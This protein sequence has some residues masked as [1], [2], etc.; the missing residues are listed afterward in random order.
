[1]FSVV[2]LNYHRPNN[3]RNQILPVLLSMSECKDIIISHG[4]KD[5]IFE[6]EHEKVICRD[7]TNIDG[8]WG[9]G[10]R[11]M[12]ALDAKTDFIVFLDDDVL[13]IPENL[14]RLVEHCIREPHILHGSRDTGRTVSATGYAAKVPPNGRAKV[15]LTQCVVAHQSK[16]KHYLDWI[17]QPEQLEILIAL[18]KAQPVFNGE[19]ITFSLCNG[20]EHKFYQDI[21]MKGLPSPHAICSRP[22]HYE[23][24]SK[25]VKMTFGQKETTVHKN[26]SYW[27]SR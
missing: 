24:R 3:I 19:D 4:K 20:S 6:S 8:I 5:T 15:I 16:V 26:E 14:K 23:H 1:M 17:M 22:G 2:I 18:Q 10:R 11:F 21:P 9:V 12:A 7:D 25:I 13:P 27:D